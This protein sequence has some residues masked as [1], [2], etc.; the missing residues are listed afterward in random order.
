MG[1]P[2]HENVPALRK[3]AFA[4]CSRPRR[5]IGMQVKPAAH[6]FFN[7]LGYTAAVNVPA[8]RKAA[9][10]PAPAIWRYNAWLSASPEIEPQVALSC[11]ALP[12]CCF[13]AFHVT[14]SVNVPAARMVAQRPA[15]VIRC[16]G[17]I[18]T[19]GA[20]ASPE[21][22]AAGRFSF[23]PAFPKT[24][25]CVSRFRFRLR[26]IVTSV[27]KTEWRG[28]GADCRICGKEVMLYQIR[29]TG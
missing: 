24:Y 25:F 20:C 5:E 22:R 16:C 10:R 21:I 18:A 7:P 14:I 23:S 13:L 19:P 6:P 2:K 8:G 29:E 28:G 3:V 12:T 1:Y 4:A 17:Q 11:F 27:D 26:E 9:K 15:L